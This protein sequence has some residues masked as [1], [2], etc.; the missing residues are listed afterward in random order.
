M[1]ADLLREPLSI[2]SGDLPGPVKECE[3]CWR[4]VVWTSPVQGPEATTLIEEMKIS[5]DSVSEVEAM[6]AIFGSSQHHLTKC[7]I[8]RIQIDPHALEAVSCLGEEPFEAN[9]SLPDWGGILLLDWVLKGHES[10]PEDI[11]HFCMIVLGEMERKRGALIVDGPRMG[12]EAFLHPL[13]GESQVE[14]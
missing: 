10:S 12:Y 13:R 3:D 2:E 6:G 8:S 7:E 11:S 1:V 4:P 14:R 9:H 5:A